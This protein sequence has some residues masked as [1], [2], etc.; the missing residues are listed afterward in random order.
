MNSVLSI[1]RKRIL[2][3]SSKQTNLL[4][5]CSEVAV[6]LLFSEEEP[7]YTSPVVEEAVV[8]V[9]T[10]C[11][12]LLNSSQ[13]PYLKVA[14]LN[15]IACQHRIRTT[16]WK[17]TPTST[18][19]LSP[20]WQMLLRWLL[21]TLRNVRNAKL[22]STSTPRSKQVRRWTVVKNKFGIA[23]SAATRTSSCWMKKKSLP[24]MLSTI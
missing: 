14:L 8:E 23:S 15:P 3:L 20:A 9:D 1:L 5:I 17:Q 7:V 13:C 21:E 22:S 12:P 19:W 6:G 16:T 10:Q 2:S 18:E 11:K 24:Q 4:P